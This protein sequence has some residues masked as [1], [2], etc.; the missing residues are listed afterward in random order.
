[1]NITLEFSA[2]Q[3]LPECIVYI[4]KQPKYQGPVIDVIHI[5]H[6]DEGTMELSIA[7]TNKKP[8]DTV[9]NSTGDIVEDKSFE[10]D[11][12]VIDKYDLEELKWESKYQA[13]NGVVYNKCLFFGPPGEFIIHLENPILPWMLRTRHRYKDDDPNWQEDYNYYD[14]ACKLLEQI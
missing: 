13:S 14:K 4:N 12:I 8:E 9:V 11:R 7:F 3:K 10:L 2:I 5:E 6:F 1:M